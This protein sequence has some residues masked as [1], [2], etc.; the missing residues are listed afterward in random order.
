MFWVSIIIILMS[1][2]QVD[3]LCREYPLKHSFPIFQTLG[4]GGVHLHKQ[5]VVFLR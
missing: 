5:S 2:L 4:G 1:W 3:P